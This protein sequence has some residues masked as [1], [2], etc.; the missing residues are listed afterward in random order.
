MLDVAD[1]GE[2]TITIKGMFDV[3]T[4]AWLLA[5]CGELAART[6]VVDFAHAREV[7]NAALAFLSEQQAAAYGPRLMLCG[8]TRRQNRLLRYL[9]HPG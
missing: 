4:A 8:L 2:T 7:S 9:G 5:T 1:S 3:P 6:V